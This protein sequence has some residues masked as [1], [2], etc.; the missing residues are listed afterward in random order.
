MDWILWFE[1]VIIICDEVDVLNNVMMILNGMCWEICI[2]DYEDGFLVS[3]KI[4]IGVKIYW[5]GLN[6]NKIGVSI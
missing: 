4:F 5:V 3:E 2:V 6:L 1:G